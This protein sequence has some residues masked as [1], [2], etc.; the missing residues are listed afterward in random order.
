MNWPMDVAFFRFMYFIVNT[1]GIGG[2]LVGLISA[3]S[4]TAYALTLRNIAK[5]A[6]EPET[7]EYAYPTPRLTHEH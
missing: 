3:I 2:I 4:I 1:A 7:E 6:S 5:S